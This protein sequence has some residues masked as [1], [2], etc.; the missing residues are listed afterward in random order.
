MTK[1]IALV[2]VALALLFA[3]SGCSISSST[4]PSPAPVA[5]PSAAGP[6]YPC[7]NVQDL[8]C[9]YFINSGTPVACDVVD[10]PS[11]LDY[12]NNTSGDY[13]EYY[14][15]TTTRCGD[16]ACNDGTVVASPERCNSNNFTYNNLA[17]GGQA[18][19]AV[20]QQEDQNTTSQ[21][22]T[23]EFISSSASTTSIT[24]SASLTANAAAVIGIVFVSVR[25]QLNASV[26]RTVSTTVGN[27]VTVTIPPGITAY[28]VYGVRVQISRGDL[29]QSNSCGKKTT[30]YGNVQA[31]VPIASGW[32]VWLSGQT[33]CRVV[34]GS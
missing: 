18:W 19:E 12:C 34:S 28:G 23:T 4:T 5:A 24:L 13:Y 7:S 25:A 16:S 30:N 33:P 6:G 2:P 3:A 15:G 27:A 11:K 20:N 10:S 17:S 22:I 8:G 14:D 21:P 1:K 26:V 31:Y 9:F 32:C 29:Y